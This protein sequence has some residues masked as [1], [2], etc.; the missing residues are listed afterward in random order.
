MV[1]QKENGGK[2]KGSKGMTKYQVV[3]KGP[4]HRA[5]GLGT[6]SREYVRA[7]RQQGVDVKVTTEVKKPDAGNKRRVLIY[8]HPPNRIDMNQERKRF[9]RIILNTVWETTKVPRNWFPN[10][11][12]FDA[13][14]VP[15]VQNK[16]AM[17]NSGVKVPIFIVPHGVHTRQFTPANKKIAFKK[18]Q[19]ISLSFYLY[20]ASST[21]KTP[22]PC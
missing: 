17:I 11:N 15:S 2:E 20:L 5:G 6:A 21:A 9:H 22:K 4:T 8:H 1:F 10:I 16:K 19:K 18:I 13:V 14:C 12:K 3:W 7:L